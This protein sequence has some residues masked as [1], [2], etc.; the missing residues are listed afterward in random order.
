MSFSWA[1]AQGKFRPNNSTR[2][3]HTIEMM[4]SQFTSEHQL[5]E[6][7][8]MLFEILQSLDISRLLDQNSYSGYRPRKLHSSGSDED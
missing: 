3:I 2:F 6:I 8:E 7:K 5:K 1:V 4:L